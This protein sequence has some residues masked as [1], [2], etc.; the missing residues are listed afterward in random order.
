MK[1]LALSIGL[2]AITGQA[3]ALSCARPDPVSTFERLAA[4]P[5][6]TYVVLLGE[7]GFDASLLPQGVENRARDPDPITAIFQGHGL[8]YDGFT[9]VQDRTITLQSTC[10][11]PWCGSAAP[12]RT[13]LMFAQIEDDNLTVV[14][15][16][17]GGRIFAPS[18]TAIDAMQAC[19]NGNCPTS[20]PRFK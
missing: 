18:D 1:H 5:D 14:A 20:T 6:A 3:A 10:A 4:E 7:L 17:C 8:G 9:V 19:I 15:G 12:D 16:P 2:M 13:L 11:G